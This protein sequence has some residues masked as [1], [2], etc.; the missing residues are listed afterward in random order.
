[1]EKSLKEDNQLQQESRNALEETDSDQSTVSRVMA[2]LKD[3]INK[4]FAVDDDGNCKFIYS[5]PFP[6]CYCFVSFLARNVTFGGICAVF[7]YCYSIFKE[8]ILANPSETIVP[9]L[10]ELGTCLV[11]NFARAKFF[12]WLEQRGGWVCCYNYY[13][14]FYVYP[15]F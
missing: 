3:V 14:Y 13:Y 4:Y 1:M 11:V 9:W 2:H 5:V 8:F 12:E 7:M 6:L 10:I 15:H